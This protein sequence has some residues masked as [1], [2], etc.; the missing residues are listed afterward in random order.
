MQRKSVIAQFYGSCMFSFIINSQT[1][2]K[3][4]AP[5]YIPTRKAWGILYLFILFSIWCFHSFV[6]FFFSHFDRYLVKSLGGFLHF[7]DDEWCK[8]TLHVLICY[9]IILVGKLSVNCLFMSGSFQDCR[10]LW[11]LQWTMRKKKEPPLEK[12]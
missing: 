5:L 12:C 2:F 1:V 4:V 6:F 11:L 3:F 10:Q 8:T 7:P 9:L